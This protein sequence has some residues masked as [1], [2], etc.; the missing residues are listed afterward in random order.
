MAQAIASQRA[1]LREHRGDCYDTAP[2]A[3]HALMQAERLPY[4][5]WEP[6]A[7][8]GNIVNVLR[9]AGHRVIATDLN[10]RPC[11]ELIAGVD[12]L[13]PMTPFECDAIVTNPPFALA[14]KFVAV[15]MERAPVVIMLL[16]LAFLESVRRAHILD[17]GKLARVHVFAN[18]LPMMH[19]D[20]WTGKRA[21]S[22]MC[23]AWFVWD[24]GHDGPAIV[25]RIFHAGKPRQEELALTRLMG[26]DERAREAIKALNLPR[27]DGPLFERD[28]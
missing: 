16:R 11:P 17:T 8:A 27:D 20:G 19:R 28:A 1:P 4:R 5:I 22:G 14:E 10:N 12:F 13:L 23:F 24:N 18:R 7:G 2:V 9:A 6:C 25:D 3:V 15:A 21:S 26:P